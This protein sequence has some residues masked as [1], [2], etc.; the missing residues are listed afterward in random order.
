MLFTRQFRALL[1]DLEHPRPVCTSRMFRTLSLRNRHGKRRTRRVDTSRWPHYGCLARVRASRNIDTGRWN[2]CSDCRLRRSRVYGHF[3]LF[4][5]MPKSTSCTELRSLAFVR[6]STKPWLSQLT[7]SMLF[8]LYNLSRKVRRR[9][10]IPHLV[11]QRECAFVRK[12][13]MCTLHIAHGHVA[14]QLC[15]SDRVSIRLY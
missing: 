3:S 1:S 6:R 5:D 12:E 9:N 2:W 15:D 4:V 7:Y 13:L 14:G 11:Q 8:Q 10:I